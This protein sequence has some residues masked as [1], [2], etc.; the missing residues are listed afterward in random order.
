MT[1]GITFFITKYNFDSMLLLGLMVT[2]ELRVC[3]NSGS[4]KCFWYSN[5][6]KDK[7][8]APISNSIDRLGVRQQ[9]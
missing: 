3:K 7:I 2:R 1:E 5:K 9:E 6:N 8:E 4:K